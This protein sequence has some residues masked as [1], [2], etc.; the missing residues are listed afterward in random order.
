L[1][2]F[3][4]SCFHKNTTNIVFLFSWLDGMTK[5][6]VTRMNHRRMIHSIQSIFIYRPNRRTG[7][8]D[9]SVLR[10]IHTSM[11]RGRME[12]RFTELQR[13]CILHG[14]TCLGRLYHIQL[15]SGWNVHPRKIV[16]HCTRMRECD[17]RPLLERVVTTQL[18][19]WASTITIVK[20]NWNPLR[21]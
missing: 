12:F 14:L 16:L 21:K 20:S 5:L 3:L 7:T 1:F 13:A 18:V 9:T 10:T 19:L 4:Q 15:T 2:T 6:R 11:T 8:V 17:V